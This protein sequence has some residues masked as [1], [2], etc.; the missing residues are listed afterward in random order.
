VI[1]VVLNH[2]VKPPPATPRNQWPA[3]RGLRTG[4]DGGHLFGER[5]ILIAPH[6]ERVVEQRDKLKRFTSCR[7]EIEVEKRRVNMIDDLANSG[8]AAGAQHVDQGACL[9]RLDVKVRSPRSAGAPD[10]VL[11]SLKR[12]TT[13][14]EKISRLLDAI[15]PAPRRTSRR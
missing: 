1:A 10:E 12:Q 7:Q 3:N 9:H 13:L 15:D 5:K 11:A 4:G 8:P 2:I 6:V 14:A